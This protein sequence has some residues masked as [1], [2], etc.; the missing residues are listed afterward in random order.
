[1]TEA[2]KYAIFDAGDVQ[3]SSGRVFRSMKLAFKTYGRLNAAR[4]NVIVY[5]RADEVE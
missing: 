1:M 5:P 3:L 4:D 2:A